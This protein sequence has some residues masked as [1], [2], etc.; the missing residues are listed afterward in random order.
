VLETYLLIG[1][2]TVT[3]YHAIISTDYSVYRIIKIKIKINII[4]RLMVP[5][6]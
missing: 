6:L 1:R 4:D 2:E 3:E 5:E